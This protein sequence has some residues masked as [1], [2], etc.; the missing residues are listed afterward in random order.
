MSEVDQQYAVDLAKVNPNCAK[1]YETSGQGPDPIDNELASSTDLHPLSDFVCGDY[2]DIQSKAKLPDG[3]FVHFVAPVGSINCGA[4][5]HCN[6]YPLLEEKPGLVR[7]MRG[8]AS[9]NDDGSV[10][11]NP[12]GTIFAWD[13][14]YDSSRNTLLVDDTHAGCGT[15]STYKFNAQDEPT[16]V[17]VTSYD[18]STNST[19]TVFKL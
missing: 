10:S 12:D 3:K 15:Q 14:S 7:L 19:T 18:C 2:S 1:Y 13:I 4:S 9:Y 8:F 6:Y 16:L 17:L 5:G 11:Q